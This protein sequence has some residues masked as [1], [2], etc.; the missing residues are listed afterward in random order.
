MLLTSVFHVLYIVLNFKI[1]L[2]FFYK[3]YIEELILLILASYDI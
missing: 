3:N 1:K 2:F